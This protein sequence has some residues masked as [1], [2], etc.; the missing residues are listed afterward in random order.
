MST[1]FRDLPIVLD[2][3]INLFLETVNSLK[4]KEK[5]TITKSHAQIQYEPL[6]P[7]TSCEA[8]QCLCCCPPE[9]TKFSLEI[10]AFY[11]SFSPPGN[12]YCPTQN[13][14]LEKESLSPPSLCWH[15]PRWDAW[16]PHSLYRHMIFS[17]LMENIAEDPSVSILPQLSEEKWS[18]RGKAGSTRYSLG[19]SGSLICSSLTPWDDSKDPS[20]TNAAI[21]TTAT[22][23]LW[24]EVA[25][26]W[27]LGTV[28]STVRRKVHWAQ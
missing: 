28:C 4:L 17:P 18:C 14:H 20:Q 10:P 24:E 15:P 9:K 2:F 25:L 27:T 22:T 16:P 21:S 26:K 8:S 1:L 6:Y 23:T 12:T 5:M 7:P 19:T 3:L 13:G 11:Y